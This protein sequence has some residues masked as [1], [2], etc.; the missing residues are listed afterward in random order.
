MNTGGDPTGPDRLLTIAIRTARADEHQPLTVLQARSLVAAED[1]AGSLLAHPDMV[2]LPMV[3]IRSGQVLVA[4]TNLG[5]CGFASAVFRHD[6]DIELDGLHVEPPEWRDGVGKALIEEC[7]TLGRRLN[8]RAI[9]AA[10]HPDA[11]GFFAACGFEEMGAEEL[12]V[13]AGILFRRRLPQ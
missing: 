11:R 9:H 1:G 10:A 13:G 12:E 3:Q 5:L 4:E 2:S 7:C 8:A 6:G